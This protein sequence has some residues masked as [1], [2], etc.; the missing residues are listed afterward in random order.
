MGLPFGASLSDPARFLLSSGATADYVE[1]CLPCASVSVETLYPK[2][3]PSC[4]GVT[5]MSTGLP[6]G[7]NDRHGGMIMLHGRATRAVTCR[8][9][10]AAQ[11][12]L[13]STAETPEVL[14]MTQ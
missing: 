11:Q 5:G 7:T 1:P 14:G 4:R 12:S 3:L 13:K 8:S 10:T 9:S 6:M 2:A